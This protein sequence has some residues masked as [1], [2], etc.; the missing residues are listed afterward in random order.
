MKIEKA[1]AIHTPEIL[2]VHQAAFGGQ[3]GIEIRQLVES[4]LEDKTAL[5][6]FSLVAVHND[7]IIGHILFTAAIVDGARAD[8]SAQ[9]L[10]P[11][12]IL[13]DYQRTGVG[14]LLI[15]TG[16]ETLRM[17]GTDLVFVLGHPQ[18]YVRSDFTPAGIQG[19]EAPYPIPAEHS[20]AWMVQALSP[21]ILGTEKGRIR[22]SDSLNEPQH[23]RE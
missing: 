2:A 6:R 9:I 15:K 3:K 22:C 21:G 11:L 10:A 19:F 7:M 20:D 4:L 12:A 14:T 17:E 1:H 23:W 13:P 18:Y 5:P 16:L 8:L